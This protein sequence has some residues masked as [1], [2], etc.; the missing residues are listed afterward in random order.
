M[1]EQLQFLRQVPDNVLIGGVALAA[2]LFVV[3]PAV[4]F[5]FFRRRAVRPEPE[6]PDLHIDLAAFPEHGPAADGPRLEFYGTPVRLAVL[7]LRPRAATAPC[8]RTRSFRN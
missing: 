8:L 3:L 6:P 1:E 7:V 2:L 5:L 4:L